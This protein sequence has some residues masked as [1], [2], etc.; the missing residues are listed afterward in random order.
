MNG[1]APAKKRRT[2]LWVGGGVLLFFGVIAVGG[3]MLAVSLFRNNMTVNESTESDAMQQFEAVRSRYPGQQP[4]IQLVD[5]HPEYVAE[6]ASQS[7]SS[8]PLSAVHVMAYDRDEG[9]VV[10]FSLPFWLLRMKSGPIRISAYQ[11]GWD[12]HGVSF[13]IEDI[14]KHG[15]G[16]IVDAAERDEGRV[17]VWAE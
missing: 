9:K 16:I 8:T 5:G 1:E 3:I 7:A 2:W 13:R 10:T 12:D 17:L 15:P 11:Q 14:E 4:L 6:R